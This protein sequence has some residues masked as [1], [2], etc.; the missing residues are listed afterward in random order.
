M[1]RLSSTTNTDKTD[2]DA[3]SVRGDV[4]IRGVWVQVCKTD[5]IG[6]GQLCRFADGDTNILVANHNGKIRATDLICTHADADL[7]TGFLGPDG[8]RCPLHLSVFDLAT[9]RPQNPPA[10]RPLRTFNVKI[11]DGQVYVRV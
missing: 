10:E 1:Q 5:E 2:D 6:D 11:E 3:T 8:V 7:S 9:G 4:G